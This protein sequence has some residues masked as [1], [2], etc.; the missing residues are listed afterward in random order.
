MQINFVPLIKFYYDLLLLRSTPL[1]RSVLFPVA[2][3][4]CLHVP[5]SS[6]LYRWVLLSDRFRKIQNADGYLKRENL[7]QFSEPS[8]TAK[9]QCRFPEFGKSDMRMVNC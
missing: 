8:A 5:S 7:L 1:L 6:G 2:S 3:P 4:A 9:T